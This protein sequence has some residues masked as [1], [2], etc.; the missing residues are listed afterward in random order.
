MVEIESACL[1]FF[2]MLLAKSATERPMAQAYVTFQFDHFIDTVS[3]LLVTLHPLLL[4]CIPVQG[5]TGNI[6]ATPH[7]HSGV[8]MV[9]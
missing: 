3:H 4:V 2:V 7:R 5:D 8:P 6:H 1:G 9:P